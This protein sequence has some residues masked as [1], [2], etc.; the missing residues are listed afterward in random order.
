[1]KKLLNEPFI[2][3]DCETTGLDTKADKLI[4]VAVC[5]FTL[6]DGITEEYQTLVNPNILIPPE[7]TAIHH[8]TD[9][10]VVD[11]PSSKEA[12]PRVL[13]M[14]KKLPIIG[15]N[16]RFDT[17]ILSNEAARDA[18]PCSLTSNIHIDTLRLARLYGESPSNSLSML[19]SHFGIESDTAHRAMNDVKLNITVFKK[20]V[21][22]FN[23]LA[24]VLERLK[25]PIK[26]RRMPLGKHKGRD[27]SDIPLDYLAWASRQ[28]FDGDLL[29][30]I[31]S[32]LSRRKKT[33]TFSQAGNPFSSL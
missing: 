23:T 18:I 12:I 21:T 15:H 32:E 14:T 33:S 30:S 26:M 5:I 22:Q 11:Q 20:L 4:E 24:A 19:G 27:F 17:D 3:I 7:T 6:Q 9:E 29:F 10:M 31:K 2:C 25:K 28:K 1:M 8:I 13:K 16:I